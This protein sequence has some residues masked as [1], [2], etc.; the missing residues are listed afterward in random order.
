MA[1]RFWVNDRSLYD[2]RDTGLPWVILWT[3][4]FEKLHSAWLGFYEALGDPEDTRVNS[5]VYEQ[6]KE[7]LRKLARGDLITPDEAHS[8]IHFCLHVCSE[9][10]VISNGWFCLSTY[11]QLLMQ[12]GLLRQGPEKRALQHYRYALHRSRTA[13]TEITGGLTPIDITLDELLQLNDRS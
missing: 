1:F 8:F 12:Q 10:R 4:T 5:A 6:G 7:D 13:P 11:I 3:T 2:D 9:M